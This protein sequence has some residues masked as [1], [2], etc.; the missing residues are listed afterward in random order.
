MR[1][2]REL[3][4]LQATKKIIYGFDVA[5]TTNTKLRAKRISS[6]EHPYAK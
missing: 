6:R 4:T 5:T 2:Q 1:Y 3:D